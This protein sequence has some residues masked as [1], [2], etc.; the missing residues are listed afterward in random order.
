MIGASV[1]TMVLLPGLAVGSDMTWL[2]NKA[3]PII[4]AIANAEEVFVGD[5]LSLFSYINLV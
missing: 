4:T 5:G 3:K 2:G 1:L